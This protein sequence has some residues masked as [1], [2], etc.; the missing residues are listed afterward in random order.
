MDHH[1]VRSAELPSPTQLQRRRRRLPSAP[2]VR[3]PLPL[4]FRSDTDAAGVRYDEKPRR[5]PRGARFG[6]AEGDSH[7][8]AERP[9]V[10]PLHQGIVTTRND[11]GMRM[12]VSGARRRESRGPLDVTDAQ[13]GFDEP[14][15]ASRDVKRQT[16]RAH[17]HA[18]DAARRNEM[19][20]YCP[21]RSE[22]T[23]AEDENPLPK[24]KIPE[25]LLAAAEAD[26]C[27]QARPLSPATMRSS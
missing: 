3:H 18:H 17:T 22:P 5:R 27:P 11:D 16:A 14:R 26:D 13:L 6:Q 20:A 12:A 9:P 21:P 24:P 1:T 15:Q 25:E 4:A 7:A 19:P 2:A 10:A 8:V 23:V